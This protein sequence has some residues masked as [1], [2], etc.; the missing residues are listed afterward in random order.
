MDTT[1][2]GENMNDTKKLRELNQQSK[3]LNAER[4]AI[5]EELEATKEHR[6]DLRKIK[7]LCRKRFPEQKKKMSKLLRSVNS[8]FSEADEGKLYDLL[9]DL[10][11][12]AMSVCDTVQAFAMACEGDIS[13]TYTTDDNDKL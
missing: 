4:K 10:E 5:R 11:G 3:E 1:P 13:P 12:S 7:A 6:A 2:K 9:S 8:A